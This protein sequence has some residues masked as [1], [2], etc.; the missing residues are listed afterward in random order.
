MILG[1]LG[2]AVA[3]A[4]LLYLALQ[5]RTLNRSVA[6]QAYQ[7]IVAS[8]VSFDGLFIEHPTLRQFVY[9]DS[10]LPPAGTDLGNQARSVVD[11]LL[12]VVDA[13]YQLRALVPK[14]LVPSWLNFA[15]TVL[16]RP[17]VREYLSEHPEWFPI[18]TE[19]PLTMNG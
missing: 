13:T 17:A 14:E 10:S 19:G 8:Q 5:T 6:A 18:A 7:A 12:N 2:L 16:A 3:F 9:E 11:I 4:S 1:I 15:N